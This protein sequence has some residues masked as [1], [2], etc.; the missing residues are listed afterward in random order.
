MDTK[1]ILIAIVVVVAAIAVVMLVLSM[2]GSA[3]DTDPVIDNGAIDQD[4]VDETFEFEFFEIDDSQIVVDEGA[5]TVEEPEVDS[6]PE[7]EDVE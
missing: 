3:P 6:D 1:K 4:V 2:D 7:T 5:E